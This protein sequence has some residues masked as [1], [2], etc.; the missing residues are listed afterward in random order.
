MG[1]DK[2]ALP[3]AGT[4]LA[5]H[6]ARLVQESAG[7]VAIL[8]DPARYGSLG[9]PVHR[10]LIPGCG[11]IGGIYTALS[12]TSTDWNLIVA[13]DMPLLSAETL[14]MLLAR[15]PAPGTSLIAASGPDREPEPLCALYHRRCLPVVK[16]AIENKRFRMK[17]LQMELE[18]EAVP[19][20]SLALANLNTPEEWREFSERSK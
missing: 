7:T 8:G 12:L 3:Y 10:D 9:Y 5:N 17:D 20:A 13:C 14:G 6:I 2:A 16:R 19:V 15:T 4:T 11:P 18:T 1:R